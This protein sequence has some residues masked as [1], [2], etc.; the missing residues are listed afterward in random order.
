MPITGLAAV[1]RAQK[2]SAPSPPTSL[3][4]AG[5]LSEGLLNVAVFIIACIY[6]TTI[7]AVLKALSTVA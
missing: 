6:N 1:A 3:T 2:W 5:S 7:I 4:A